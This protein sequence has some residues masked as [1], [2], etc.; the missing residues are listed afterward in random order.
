MPTQTYISM[1]TGVTHKWSQCVAA[2]SEMEKVLR[3][4][5]IDWQEYE[6]LY[7]TGCDFI[8]HIK[9]IAGEEPIEG[10][11]GDLQLLPKFIVCASS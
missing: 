9:Q 7:M 4:T 10:S 6:E 1:V 2:I 11:N 8:G 5:M 3:L